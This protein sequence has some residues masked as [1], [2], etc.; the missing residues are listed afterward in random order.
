M[1][2]G[3]LAVAAM[4][5]AV[6]ISFA[7]PSLAGQDSDGSDT[8]IVVSGASEGATTYRDV[9]MD[10]ARAAAVA[11]FYHSQ[12]KKVVIVDSLDDLDRPRAEG[13]SDEREGPGGPEARPAEPT[14][15]FSQPEPEGREEAEGDERTGSEEEAEDG[16]AEAAEADGGSSGGNGAEVVYAEYSQ[17]SVD[18]DMVDIMVDYLVS[19]GSSLDDA[20]DVLSDAVRE[21]RQLSGMI[22]CEFGGQSVPGLSDRRDG[23]DDSDEDDECDADPVQVTGDDGD[24]TAYETC[25]EHDS[26]SS[27]G[28]EC[29]AVAWS[30]VRFAACATSDGDASVF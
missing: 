17:I 11:D 2:G 14:G 13:P 10:F 8:V 6:C 22:F 21:W 9:A 16:T 19:S 25:P 29:P 12:D 18:T 3:V 24:E 5:I 23:Q 4:L 20:A 30:A 7:S 26:E 1:K 27:G 15:Q 28:D